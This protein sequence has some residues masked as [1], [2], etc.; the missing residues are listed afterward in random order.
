M[1]ADRCTNGWQFWVDRGGTFTDIVA[2]SPDGRLLTHKLLSENPEHYIDAAVQGIRVILGIE[3]GR[4][5]PAGLID[6][7]R[8]GTTVATNALLERRGERLV[9]VTT[10]GF[11]DALRIGYQTRPKIF[12]RHIELPSLLYESVVEVSERYSADGEELLALDI[13]AVRA[14]LQAAYDDGIRAAS[15]V[16]MH[17]YRY[18]A[19]EQSAADIARQIG[20]TQISVSHQVCPSIK[21]VGRGDTTVV[22]AY[23]SPIL[24]RY[25]EHIA[26][27][28]GH[29][30]LMFMQSNGGLAD[31]AFFHGKDSILSG[32]AGGVVGAVKTAVM[33]G[34]SKIISFD[35]GGTSTDVAHY[36]GEYERTFETQTA[37]VRIKAPMMSIHT[38]AAGGGSILHFDGGRLRV[39]P[40]SA[41]ADPGPVCYR[42]G[43]PLCVTDANVMV[44]KIQAHCFPKVFGPGA[45]QCMDEQL[46]QEKFATLAAE[47]ESETGRK[48][49]PLEAADGFLKIAVEN[50]VNAVKQISVQRGYDV[51]EYTLNCFGG[52]AGQFACRV[53][54]ALAVTSV[55]VHPYAGVLSAYGMGLAEQRLIL[56][57][58]VQAVLDEA[59]VSKLH[60]VFAALKAEGCAKMSA[61]GIDESKISL[62]Q[63]LHLRYQGSDTTLLVDFSSYA[64]ICAAF[65]QQHRSQFSFITPEKAL[66]VDAVLLEVIGHG[67]Q[68]SGHHIVIE[69][70]TTPVE[71]QE[72]VKIYSGG[73][74]YTAALY[75]RCELNPGNR[76]VGP[77]VIIETNATTV[78]EAGWDARV[79]VNREL[80]L[81]RIQAQPERTAVGTHVDPVMLEVFN[82]LFMS[83]A[84]QMGVVLQ[85]TSYSVNIKERLDFSCAVF[86]ADGALVANAPHIP[87]HLGS[88]EKSVQII[89]R[90]R[91]ACMKAG[92][93]FMLNSPYNGGTH[94]PDITLI[95]PVFDK[96]GNLLFY[97]A[98]RGH[99]AEIGSI[100]PGS[101]PAQSTHI[102]QEGVLINDFLLVQA[103]HLREDETRELFTSGCYPSRNFRHNLGDLQAQIAANEKGLCEL[104]KMVSH[105][106]LKTVHAYMRHVQSNAEEM[107]R[108]VIDQLQ[109]GL[110][111]YKMDIGA[112]IKVSIRVDKIKR[113][114][115][116]DFSGTSAQLGCN[117]NAPSAVCTAAVLYVFRT[118][119]DDDIPLNAGCLKPLRIIIPKGSMLDPVYPAAVAA[120]NVETSQALTDALFGALGT[121]A[122][123]QGTMNNFTFGNK[124]RQYYETICGGAGAGSGYNGCSAVHTHMTN[125][126][127]TDPEVLESR[128]PVL[129]QSFAIRRGSGGQ[130]AYCGGDGVI[131]R[132]CFRESMTASIL[133]GHRRVPP[134]GL[135][136]GFPGQVGRNYVERFDGTF[137]ELPG[138]AQVEMLPGD[139][140][141]IE[142]PG[143]GG[144]GKEK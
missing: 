110:F 83:I 30:R 62:L 142:T 72:Q 105:F 70:S 10:R 91:R 140:F 50:M 89:A 107:V 136:G 106:G 90:S 114:A 87:V 96:T 13:N 69:Q 27:E 59:L 61:Q 31:A 74:F 115:E 132:L 49:S 77:A 7:V 71:V 122:A 45:D 135:A 5:I 20:F 40:D 12:A 109:D 126:R 98:C 41:G 121:A 117:F 36:S 125:T 48:I 82:N 73:K 112:R 24:L 63:K 16:F 99:H 118:L 138:N 14:G 101:M 102:D 128:F 84:E 18:P 22:D 81:K 28:L 39:G 75:Q 6:T 51:C 47:I 26:V 120:G 64:E 94:L 111:V 4:E 33:A 134:Y 68:M 32:P 104:H 34:F 103:G 144:Y 76:I 8:M 86:D 93:V 29:A 60:S 52:A 25:I 141:V 53:A 88:M 17:A 54:D 65:A 58:A 129:V 137:I 127:L 21:F 97:T 55:L 119:V 100:T 2:K 15:I 9:L 78:V 35:M 130:G 57:R 108:R 131:R 123:S 116:I 124:S 44:G 113:T 43:G 143:G 139:C 85:N 11:A 42:R 66:I 67:E 19:H 38:V 95:T 37:G 80:L 23:L 3:S 56:E 46:V 92:D 1:A 79:G 133:S